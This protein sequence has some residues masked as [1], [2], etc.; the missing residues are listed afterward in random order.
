MHC[1][2][3]LPGALFARQHSM[4]SVLGPWQLFGPVGEGVSFWQAPEDGTWAPGGGWCGV[5]E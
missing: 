1:W 3:P 5:D 2:S 4:M